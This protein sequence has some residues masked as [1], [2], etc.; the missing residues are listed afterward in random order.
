MHSSTRAKLTVHDV[1]AFKDRGEKI[2]MVTAYDRP[3][4]ALADDADIDIILVGDSLGSNVLGHE[5]SLRVTM[6][7]MAT[8]CRAVSAAVARVFVVG[9]LPYMSYQPSPRDAVLNAGRLMAEGGA[10]AVKLEGGSAQVPAIA[11]IVGAGIPVMGHLGL[12]PQSASAL[13]GLKVQGREASSAA[14]LI[15]E[16]RA[17]EDAGV[18]ALV[19]EAVPA[20]VAQAVTE[21]LRVP[22]VGIGA[23]PHCDGQVLVMHDLFNLSPHKPRFAK[24]Y[25]DAAALF[26][27]GFAAYRA[28]VKERAFPAEEHSFKMK[29]EEIERLNDLRMEVAR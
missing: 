29:R 15:E 22:T 23:G 2:A 10:D 5:N 14:R 24:Q 28:D 25:A 16:A 3:L 19:L 17:L 20:R 9:D 13:G 1:Q 4:A 7:E 27:S 8:H 6:D 12:T 18:F 21:S 26:R 11:A